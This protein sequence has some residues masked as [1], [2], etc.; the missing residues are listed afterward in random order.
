MIMKRHSFFQKEL[1]SHNKY[2]SVNDQNVHRLAN[3]IYKVVYDLSV[4][5]FENFFHFR[6]KYTLHIPLI[7]TE[8][9]GK[10]SISLVRQLGMLF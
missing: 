6:N 5:D 10:N 3:E 4:G 7:N 8:L 9:K 2:F 1:F